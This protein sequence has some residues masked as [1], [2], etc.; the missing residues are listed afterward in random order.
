MNQII[1]VAD[2]MTGALDIFPVVRG[3][4]TEV[5]IWGDPEGLRSLAKLLVTLADY[6]Q[7]ES[8]APDGSRAHTHLSPNRHLGYPSSS[9]QISRGDAKGSCELPDF[10]E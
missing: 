2:A 9:V 6:D 4:Q 5:Q 3:Q 10:M 1:E 8:D 7:S